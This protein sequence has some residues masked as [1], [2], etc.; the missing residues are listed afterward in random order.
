MKKLP[1]SVPKHLSSFPAPPFPLPSLFPCH[2]PVVRVEMLRETKGE[3]TNIQQQDSPSFAGEEVFPSLVPFTSN[4]DTTKNTIWSSSNPPSLFQDPN[5][6]VE[7]PIEKDPFVEQG[8]ERLNRRRSQLPSH[9]SPPPPLS[10]LQ[11]YIPPSLPSKRRNMD[12]LRDRWWDAVSSRRS[13]TNMLLE[14]QEVLPRYRGQESS[15]DDESAYS[16]ETTTQQEETLIPRSIFSIDASGR[17]TPKLCRSGSH[18]IFRKSRI[19]PRT[20]FNPYYWL[21]WN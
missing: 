18:F 20:S 1:N 3:A 4:Q 8:L 21:S 13:R 10:H 16:T 5:Q 7:H 12:R 14:L 2:R 11:D 6:L 19:Y 9:L 15:S 17:K